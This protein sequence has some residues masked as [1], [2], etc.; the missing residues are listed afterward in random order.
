VATK[1]GVGESK[2]VDSFAAGAEAAQAAMAQAGLEKCDLVLLFA[3]VD[4]DHPRVLEG[5]RTVTGG[6][7][8]SGCSGEGIITQAGPS[9]EGMFTRDGWVE[10]E[11]AVGVMV[12]ASDSLRF[13]TYCIDGLKRSSRLAGETLGEQ[14]RE[15]EGD[16][17]P[18]LLLMFPDGLSVNTSAFYAGIESKLS[19]PLPFCGGAAADNMSYTQTFQYYDDQV[20]SDAASCVAVCGDLQYVIGVNHGC[21]PIGLDKTVTRA[22]E[23]ILF[24]IEGETAWDFV[25]QYLDEDIENLTVE[26]AGVICLGERLPEE[27]VSEYGRYIIRL[28]LGE[29]EDGS[30]L[31]S[32]DIETGSKIR[33]TRRDPDQIS[34]G[35]KGLAEKLEKQLEGK[36][37]SAVLQFDCAAR[38]KTLFGSEVKEKGIDVIQDVLGKDVP[39]LG[40]FTYGE[41]APIGDKN[42]AHTATVALLVIR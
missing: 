21:L 39:W 16:D 1:A 36:K 24:E 38:G 25:K 37:P 12:L 9:G 42:Y 2:N 4:H 19:E 30:L 15:Q 13:F 40:F 33:M 14:L 5:V 27:A 10:G 28:P 7:P 6:A 34:L 32:T 18:R 11:R 20:L 22:E 35:A 23:N 29:G 8:L 41:L 3:T 26:A 17:P 31:L